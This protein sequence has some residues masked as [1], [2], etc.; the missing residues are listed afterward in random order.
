MKF[1]HVS[2]FLGAIALL[3]ALAHFWAGPIEPSQKRAEV[4]IGEA[5]ADIRDAAVRRFK[6]EEAKPDAPPT[7]MK[8]SNFDADEIAKLSIAMFGG[9]GLILAGVGYM[10]HEPKRAVIVGA[11]LSTGAV[12]FQFL[13]WF[14]IALLVVALIAAVIVSLGGS[15]G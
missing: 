2:V 13:S 6:S 15:L 14:V 1:T 9:L 12:T 11:A 7:R 5:A 3:G 4:S 10:R 8:R